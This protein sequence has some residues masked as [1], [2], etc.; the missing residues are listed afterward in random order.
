MHIKYFL[1]N[2]FNPSPHPPHIE[3]NGYS[4]IYF[5]RINGESR[6]RRVKRYQEAGVDVPNLGEKVFLRLRGIGRIS[7]FVH[8]AYDAFIMLV[9]PSQRKAYLLGNGLRA[10]TTCF[11]GNPPLELRNGFLLMLTKRPSQ[12]MTLSELA[13]LINPHI[14][15]KSYE[16]VMLE[17]ELGSG[18]G[19]NHIQLYEACSIVSRAIESPR[20]M[21]ALMH[22]E[23]SRTLVWGFMVG[24]FYESHYS[25][26]RELLTRNQLER[27][28]LE[29][30]FRYDSAF[31]SA[32]R[33]IEC[34]LG[35]PHFKQAEIALLL[36]R[37][38][39][40]FQTSFSSSKHRSWHEMFSSRRKWWKYENI[41][42]YYLKLRNAV[43]A[44]GNPSPPHI[45]MEDQVFEIQYL[46]QAMLAE[47]LLPEER[48]EEPNKLIQR[49][50]HK[51]RA[52]D[53]GH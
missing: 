32:F 30:R 28:Y 8:G 42:A 20:I 34:V 48:K 12:D 52:A 9:A 18:T 51:R 21:D 45:V 17:G 10:A 7:V 39:H 5:G 6:E 50:R 16:S 44:H 15:P 26:E 1:V 33:G 11:H 27:A 46:L 13:K 35:K 29:N 24:S 4:E 23:Y 41:I 40:E 47:I 25:R 43:S 22:L 37:I 49:T 31:V 2:G 36:S 38:D 3:Q 53:L 19:I 14:S